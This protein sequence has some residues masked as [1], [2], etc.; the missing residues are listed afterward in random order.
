MGFFKVVLGLLVGGVAA[1]LLTVMAIWH[2]LREMDR[3]DRGMRE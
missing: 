2:L 1:V 3:I